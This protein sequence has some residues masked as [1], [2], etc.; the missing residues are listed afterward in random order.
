MASEEDKKASIDFIE[1]VYS[2]DAGKD[3]VTNSLGFI[4]PFSTFSEADNPSDPLAAQVIAGM[5]SS[6]LTPVSWSFETFPNQKFKDDFGTALL[7]YCNGDV[8]WDMVVSEVKDKWT[9]QK[10]V[11]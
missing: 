1:W 2:C 4:S 6:E 10:A 3:Y 5:N 9:A 8:T 11:K 7:N